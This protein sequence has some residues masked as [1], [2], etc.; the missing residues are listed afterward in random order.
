MKKKFIIEIIVDEDGMS[1]TNV[2]NN[3]FNA[4]ELLGLL[5]LKKMDIIDQCINPEKFKLTR[6]CILDNEEYEVTKEGE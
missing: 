2:T 5:E 4:I 6:R 3:G 1:H